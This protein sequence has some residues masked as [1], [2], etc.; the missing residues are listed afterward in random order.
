MEACAYSLRSTYL[1]IQKPCLNSAVDL[2]VSDIQ[3]TEARVEKEYAIILYIMYMLYCV[4]RAQSNDVE[5]YTPA[6]HSPALA[7]ARNWR[8]N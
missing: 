3:D 4:H 5:M 6:I 1:R 7:R 2:I 8:S